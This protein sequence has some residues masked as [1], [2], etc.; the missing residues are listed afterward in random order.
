MQYKK[1]HS[2]NTKKTIIFLLL[3]LLVIGVGLLVL[4]KTGVINLYSRDQSSTSDSPKPTNTVN[5]DP[6]TEQEQ[7][8]GDEQK[9]KIVEEESSASTNKPETAEVVIVDAS[10]YEDEIEVRAFVANVLE[11]GTCTY[12]FKNGASTITKSQ[13]AY[14]DAS[15]TPCTTL[16]VP[17]A[18]FAN[19]G[20]WNLTVT[21]ES[22]TV[23]G[24]KTQ[25][26]VI[27]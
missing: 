9:A 21:F 18:E 1:P 25:E 20:S 6:P 27:E 23:K 2:K 22:T 24:S 26:V 19:P 16:V 3:S 17:R 5:Y 12:I 4:E 14:P 11:I 10:Q 8:A 13:S 7:S 15:T